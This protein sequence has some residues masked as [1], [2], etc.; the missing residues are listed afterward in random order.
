MNLRRR[1]LALAATATLA[2]ALVPTPALGAALDGRRIG[3]PPG[4]SG[5]ID[6]FAGRD[7]KVREKDLA[8]T[9]ADLP[10]RAARR[11]PPSVTVPVWFHVMTNGSLGNLTSQ[12]ID[13]QIPC[14]TRVR[15]RRRWD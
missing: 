14:S 9:H 12:Q 10:A 3:L 8:E 2:L 7:R 4:D 13:A 1:A 5:P 6:M 11:H 15:R